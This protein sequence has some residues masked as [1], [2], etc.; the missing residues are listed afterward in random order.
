MSTKDVTRHLFQP[1]KH[2]AAARL[3]QGRSLLDSDYNEGAELDGDEWRRAV[4]DIVGPR[5]TPDDGFSLGQ[6][7]LPGDDLTSPLAQTAPL[8]LFDPLLAFT[9]GSTVLIGGLP[10]F[11]A[12]V[13]IRAGTFYLGG[14][15]LEL[16][17]P[18]PIMFQRDFLQI[19]PDDLQQ[20]SP[21]L[22]YL[23]AWEQ[24]V[25]AV[26]DEELQDRALGGPDTMVRTRRFRRV[27]LLGLQNGVTT[28]REG[29]NQLVNLLQQDGS[30][31]DCNTSELQSAG[32]LQLVFQAGSG[33]D[34]CTPDPPAQYLGTENQTLR[35][36]LAD[37][38]SFV[39]SFDNAA[40][41]YRVNLVNVVNDLTGDQTG[42][43]Q[44]QLLT[45]PKDLE[46]RPIKDRVIEIL[47]FAALLDGTTPLPP[48][49]PHFRKAAAEMGVFTTV[50]TGL[51]GDGITFTIDVSGD[52]LDQLKSLISSWSTDHPSFDFLNPDATNTNNP[53]R[54]MYAR[55]WHVASDGN[56]KVP[57]NTSPSGPPLADTG[58]IPVFHAQGRAGD[59]WVAA[60]RPDAPQEIVPF[61]ILSNDQ[62]VPPD[63]PRHFFAPLA[64]LGW[65]SVDNVVTSIDD[66]RSRM[67]RL[68]DAGCT[69]F[70]VGDGLHTV[71]DFTVIQDA[72]NALPPDG[73]RVT[74][75]PG[76]YQQKVEI[77]GRTNVI[78]E[79]CGDATIIQ[80][81]SG[82][83][84][85]QLFAIDGDS[86]N[87]TVANL[88]FHAVEQPAIA[89]TG[90]SDLAL[91]GLSAFAFVTS[92]AG[93]APGAATSNAGLIELED[94]NRSILQG[95]LLE[96]ARRP[97]IFIEGT[98]ATT[99]ETAQ[100]SDITLIDISARGSN[101]V[102]QAPTP[103]AVP[104]I[105][106]QGMQSVA[107]R[108]ASL[109]TF[110][111]VA[112]RLDPQ[113]AAAA[114]SNFDVQLSELTIVASFHPALEV[115]PAVDI[116][117]GAD[118]VLE[119]SDIS[120]DVSSA[121]AALIVR[122]DG[123][124]VRGNT[125]NG[126]VPAPGVG[127][128]SWS[129]IQVRGTSNA[130]EI[131]DNEISGGLGHGITIGSVLWGADKHREATGA[132]QITTATNNQPR[133]VT[134]DLSP[135]LQGGT[136]LASDEGPITDLT[137]AD[138]EITGFLTNGISMLTVLGLAASGT[139]DLLQ[140]ANLR[141]ER[142]DI[143]NNLTLVF[144]GIPLRTD[145]LPFP[146]ASPDIVGL[147]NPIG[148]RLLPYGGIVLASVTGSLVIAGNSIEGNGSSPVEP[149][150]G[151]FVLSGDG[152]EVVQN[153]IAR[154]G[155]VAVANDVANDQ[156]PK[157]G[158]RAGI[159]VMLAGTE[160]GDTGA[161]LELLTIDPA[162]EPST[163]NSKTVALRVYQNSVQQPEGRALHAV[164][165]GAITVD[166]NF[167]SSQGFHGSA[168]INDA[169]AVGDVVFVQD[170]G[171]PVE[172]TDADQVF[173]NGPDPFPGFVAPS[174]AVS[175][176]VHN[177]TG[178]PRRFVGASGGVL[179][180]NNQVIYDWD[181][182]RP[183][184]TLP[185]NQTPVPLSYF[186]VTILTLDHATCVGNS[187]A[188]RLGGVAAGSTPPA[189]PGITE[190]L[191][192][193]VFV[194]ASTVQMA[195]N[196]FS[197]NVL[198]T[199]LSAVTAAELMNITSGNIGTHPMF[200]YQLWVGVGGEDARF[201]LSSNNVAI[202]TKNTVDFG[203]LRSSLRDQLKSFLRL[204]QQPA[205]VIT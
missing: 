123:V 134:G 1:R 196:R 193:N 104:L 165:A 180:A 200:A 10:T 166:G 163:V 4:L 197:E 30:I 138:N 128:P 11:V 158:V 99:A 168:T 117:G 29:F 129:G 173:E 175:M 13:S 88:R 44:V 62:G 24:P 98:I 95:L 81:P 120:M 68:V 205:P 57:I 63:G 125:V 137:I 43:L 70:T 176:L 20:S 17:R 179:F 136:V 187:F 118:V 58:I 40:P 121:Q 67:R 85:G 105:H 135:G 124:V 184:V 87:V 157:P 2:Y 116:D 143:Q 28:C 3:Q 76:L 111:Q 74:I 55:F 82:Q 144:D 51:G 27:R 171:A 174:G 204:L 86:D 32:R 182:K 199:T 131:R 133:F 178:S 194:G 126:I 195:R 188:L 181:V 41:L 108:K 201:F 139:T 115:Q 38:G 167:L 145:F 78:V 91:V 5:G 37:P 72:I 92:G 127:V 101:D 6:S 66:C 112:V 49:R 186:G 97:A 45:P 160:D 34:P 65:D 130:I 47:P 150:N 189:L 100:S 53:T 140:V 56:V 75:L 22:Y 21:T 71:G 89:A 170:L 148:L 59:F 64:V 152:I 60:L 156:T 102:T 8:R 151:I 90:S 159:A 61:E 149:I 183:I 94:C 79:G 146:A 15:R 154:N 77:S 18:E 110:G 39:W 114:P 42:T 9:A 96:A 46:H 106:V 23:E 35:I 198:A 12:P 83:S 54:P 192:S 69:T 191:V 36:M 153:K 25:T 33:N 169:F 84:T 162:I 107:I 122:G 50:V 31:F 109:S 113:A 19:T 132:G 73:G 26:E 48:G 161:I 155:S 203:A 16:D 142:N 93:V 141:I 202:F 119:D 177:P 172:V 164:A 147:A 7:L 52:V 80:T 190:P 14:M 185:N 103:A